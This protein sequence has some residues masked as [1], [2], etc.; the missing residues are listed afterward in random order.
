[1]ASFKV[2]WKRSWRPFC[3]GRPGAMRSWRMPSLAHHTPSRVRPV[4]PV[5]ANGVP[6]HDPSAGPC[7][8]EGPSTRPLAP[9]LRC[10]QG[11]QEAQNLVRSGSTASPATHPTRPTVAALAQPS[12]GRGAH[13]PPPPPPQPPASGDGQ[14]VRDIPPPAPGPAPP[15][16]LLPPHPPP[17]PPPLPPP[18]PPHPNPPPPGAPPPVPPPHPSPPSRGRVLPRWRGGGKTVSCYQRR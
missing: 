5:E 13:T 15:P 14:P 7:R 11:D 8:S 1:M 2:R 6:F 17:P 12:P 10:I 3:V 4:T 16:P 9:V 18:P